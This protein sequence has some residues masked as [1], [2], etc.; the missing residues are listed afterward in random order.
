MQ[1]AEQMSNME[2]VIGKQ[3]IHEQEKVFKTKILWCPANQLEGL[4]SKGMHS[5]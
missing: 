4:L 2:K 3:A 1:S 5:K